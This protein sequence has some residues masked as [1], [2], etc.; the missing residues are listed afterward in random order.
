VDVM[1][2]ACGVPYVAWLAFANVVAEE[3]WRRNEGE[4]AEG[5]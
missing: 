2:A 4:S 1:A 5:R 3:V